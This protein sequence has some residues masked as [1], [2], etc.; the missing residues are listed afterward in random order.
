M[1]VPAA[2]ANRGP[3]PLPLAG[4][5]S[6]ADNSDVGYSKAALASSLDLLY[7]RFDL[8]CPGMMARA[9]RPPPTVHPG[10]HARPNNPF[11]HS[12]NLMCGVSATCTLLLGATTG[13]ESPG[14]VRAVS[15]PPLLTVSRGFRHRPPPHTHQPSLPPVHS[16]DPPVL[17][18]ANFL[19]AA[20][21]DELMAHSQPLLQPSTQGGPDPV[22]WAGKK[23]LSSAVLSSFPQVGATNTHEQGVS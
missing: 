11:A 1:L 10:P 3:T 2:G 13:C 14:S 9:G 15:P 19:D 18:I 4:V 22:G 5:P 16:V 21:C 8:D 20:T 23:E 12:S 6:H 7:R 17:T